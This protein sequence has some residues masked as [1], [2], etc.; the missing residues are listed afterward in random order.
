[1][2]VPT[3]RLPARAGRGGGSSAA[4]PGVRAGSA[5]A[6]AAVP[7]PELPHFARRLGADV[8]FFAS[9][10]PAAVA[11]GRGGRLFRIAA[12]PPAAP[13]LVALPSPPLGVATPD[14][15][16][17]G[18]EMHAEPAPRAPLVLDADAV[19]GRGGIGRWGGND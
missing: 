2:L 5:L 17:W 6:Y 8:T 9:G 19:A 3:Q 7:R 4:G 13:A 11:W 1:A 15:Y 10:A 12:P 16:R 14:A 18:D